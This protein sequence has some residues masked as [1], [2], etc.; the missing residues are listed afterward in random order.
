MIRRAGAQA[1]KDV[2]VGRPDPPTSF[3]HWLPK[4]FEQM[5]RR[6]CRTTEGTWKRERTV[7]VAQPTSPGGLV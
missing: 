1:C 2:L 5:E 4:E 7:I 6:T 3:V